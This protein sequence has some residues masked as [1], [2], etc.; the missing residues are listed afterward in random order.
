[1]TLA[2]TAVTGGPKRTPR[3]EITPPAAIEGQRHLQ[4]LIQ[5]GGEPDQPAADGTNVTRKELVVNALRLLALH[6]ESERETSGVQSLRAIGYADQDRA[7]NLGLLTGETAYAQLAE[8][9]AWGGR[10][11]IIPGWVM[12]EEFFDDETSDLPAREQPVQST[13]I[14]ADRVPSDWAMFEPE[15]SL[16]NDRRIFS[17]AVIGSGPEHD[18]AVEA[19]RSVSGKN[20]HVAL[21]SLDGVISP[22][23]VAYDLNRMISGR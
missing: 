3:E 18:A 23:E 22:A 12:S 1:M 17:V 20:R 5:T 19:F 6:L 14:I 15:L 21:A 8:G 10:S 7:H 13:L 4:F 2:Q 16:A 11:C 9:V